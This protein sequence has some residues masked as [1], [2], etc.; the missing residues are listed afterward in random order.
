MKNN[1]AY[2]VWSQMI[3][4]CTNPN[5]KHYKNYG[6]RGIQV[7]KKW[8]NFDNFLFDMGYLGRQHHLDRIDNN[9]GYFLENCRWT[10]RVV[11]N[12]NKRIYKTNVT[13]ISGIE[14]RNNNWRVRL[15]HLGKIVVDKTINDFFE[16]CCIRKSAELL[17]VTPYITGDNHESD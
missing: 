11:N 5:N 1:H 17:Y 4:R 10:S 7:C 12:K 14:P 9:K 8:L 6:F 2:W 15:R 3:Q 16:A 13:G